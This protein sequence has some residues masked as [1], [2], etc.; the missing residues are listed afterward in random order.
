MNFK[1]DKEVKE[2]MISSK[3]T[4]NKVNIEE[5]DEIL[6]LYL[7]RIE[8]FKGENIMQWRKYLEHHPKS[9]FEDVIINSNY[10][11]L[12]K[13]GKTIAGFEITENNKYWED[14]K[15]AYYIK[16]LVTKVGSKNIGKLIIE[17]AKDLA[18]IN[19]KKYLRL[20]C[21][22]TNKK[23]NEIYEKYGFEL[24]KIGKDDYYNYSLRE[25]NIQ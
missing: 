24:V 23:L 8:W 5:I 19:N 6:K 20:D 25:C 14:N 15:D 11:C 4:I 21:L 17:I 9:E 18:K 2:K 16:K 13:E 22:S 3:I 12:R 10:F 7:E 1:L